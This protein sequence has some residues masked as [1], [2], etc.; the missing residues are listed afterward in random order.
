[1]RYD[2]TK[3]NFEEI[4]KIRDRLVLGERVI[5]SDTTYDALI[6]LNDA[7]LDN[8]VSIY[9]PDRHGILDALIAWVK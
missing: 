8:L 6:D 4:I 5:V 2:M 1:M 3:Q 9:N 7:R